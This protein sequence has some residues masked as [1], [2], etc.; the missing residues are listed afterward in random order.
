MKIKSIYHIVVLSLLSFMAIGVKAQQISVPFM[1]GF[2][3]EAE[4]QHWTLN[5]NTPVAKDQWIVGSATYSEGRHSLYISTDNGLTASYDS[6]PNIVMAY[7]TITFPQKAGKYNISFDW[8]SIGSAQQSKL[9]V[10]IG[11]EQT[12]SSGIYMDS[13]GDHGLLDIV[14]ETSGMITNNKILGQFKKLSD[15][16]NSYDYL[17]GSRKWQNY[18]IQGDAENPDVSVNLSATSAKRNYI[19]AF[20]W[21]NA[22]QKSDSC[23]LGACIDNIQIASSDLK[24]PTALAAEVHCEDSTLLLS[25]ES[26]LFGFDVEYRNVKDNFWRRL[27]NLPAADSTVQ[28]CA[29]QMK[30]EGN[31][32]IRIRGYN[33]TKT[34]TSAYASLNNVVYWCPDNHCINYIDLTGDDVE[35]RYGNRS[36]NNNLTLSC[37]ETGLLDYGEEALESRHT[38]NWIEGRYDPLT[39]ESRDANG[40]LVSPLQT[41]PEGSM[42]SVRLGNWE[43]G[44]ECESVTYSFVVDSVSQAILIMKYAIVFEDPEHPGLQSEFNIEVLDA[45]DRLINPTCGQAKF[46]FDD[47][48]EWY[49]TEKTGYNEIYWKDWTALGIDLRQYHGLTVK[50]RVTTADCGQGGHF[51]YAYFVL[52]CVS[53]TLETDNCGASSTITLN[54]PDGFTYEWTNSKGEIV[55]TERQLSADAGYETY[56]CEACMI[57]AGDCCFTLSTDFAPRYPAPEFAWKQTPK[58]CQNIVQFTNLSHVLTRY[59]DHDVH[60]KEACDQVIWEFRHQGEYSTTPADHPTLL[61]NPEGDT[62]EVALRAVLGGGMCDSILQQTVI[63]PSILSPDSIIR[64][65]LCEGETYIFAKQ[66]FEKTGVYYDYQKNYAGCDSTAI[67]YLTVHPKSPATYITDTIC[68]TDLPYVLNGFSYPMSGTFSQMLANQYDCDSLVHLSLCVIDK[69]EVAVDSLPTLCADGEQ[70]II[71]Y[72]VMANRFDSLAVRFIGTAPQKAFNDTIIYDNSITQ[73]IYPYDES[74]LPNLYH[75]QLEFYQHQSCGNQIFDLDFELQY[76]SSIVEQK[77][78]DVL[79]ILNS[80][81]NG[82]YTFTSYQW[83][84][85]DQPI[86]GATGSYL[87]QPLDT[88]ADY[89]VLLS[90]ADGVMIRTCPFRPTMHTD[91]ATFPTL[92]HTA[93]RLPVRTPEGSELITSVTIYTVLGQVYATT[94]IE[95]GEGYITAPYQE[96]NYIIRF[97]DQQG[98]YTTQR[99]IVT[100]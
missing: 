16:T 61:C 27:T 7:R 46:V 81:Y 38:V 47:A 78:N 18:Y 30:Y 52:D 51:G 39:T 14:S 45:N 35:C 21:V 41:I 68:S 25:W 49:R 95:N 64:A 69:L 62:V 77:W 87:Y 98:R 17:Y 94:L 20:I 89:S 2:E 5:Q 88:T 44:S 12:L 32:N 80:K 53:A 84:M 28:T 58:N 82:G 72:R 67:L 54:A 48:T 8:K 70:L 93:Q 57:D 11:P 92:A 19:L 43:N 63:I 96:G 9:Y 91:I 83:Y 55:S 24:R 4:L 71:D 74:I 73:I 42:A 56:T 86:S 100:R 60:T 1:C 37:T 3:D 33:E 22:N 50:V 15:G 13:N 79:A 31:Y 90:R 75:V 34:D 23:R 99:L 59:E 29:L 10:Y 40:R 76:Q 26:T 85:N 66:P 36:G 6:L 97:T 65:S